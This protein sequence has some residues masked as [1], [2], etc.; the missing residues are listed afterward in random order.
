MMNNYGFA[1]FVVVRNPA[2]PM[3]RWSG[4]LNQELLDDNFFRSAIFLASQSLYNALHKKD[5]QLRLVHTRERLA[6]LKYLNRMSFRATPFGLFSSFCLSGWGSVRPAGPHPAISSAGTLYLQR[7]FY[8]MA[9]LTRRLIH[10]SSSTQLKYKSSEAWYTSQNQSRVLKSDAAGGNITIASFTLTAWLKQLL[11]YCQTS[12]SRKAIERKL[13]IW[14]GSKELAAGLFVQLIDGGLLCA[15]PGINVTGR[16]FT[17]KAARQLQPGQLPEF[18]RKLSTGAPF[19]ELALSPGGHY[20]VYCRKAFGK[21]SVS[22]QQLLLEGVNCLARLTAPQPSA[23]LSQFISRFRSRYEAA[24][25]PL[26]KALD[27]ELGL[28]YQPHEFRYQAEPL[29]DTIA[30]PANTSEM[31]VVWTPAHA[32]IASKMAKGGTVRLMETDLDNLPQIALNELPPSFSVLWQALGEKV[33]IEQAGGCSALSLSGRFTPFDAHLC[34]ALRQVAKEEDKRNPGI[35]FAEI[36]YL[37]AGKPANV[38]YRRSLRKFEIPVLTE[39][40]VDR[41]HVL[42]L[43]DLYLRIVEGKLVLYSKKL[44]QQ[45]VPRLS[46]VYNHSREEFPLFRFLCDLQYIDLRC[47]LTLSLETM[48]PGLDYYPRVEFRDCILSPAKW[49]LTGRDVPS[50]PDEMRS[51]AVSLGLPRHYVLT[52]GDHELLFDADCDKSLGMFIQICRPKHSFFLKESF[53]SQHSSLKDEKGNLYGAQYV[54]ALVK[55]SVTYPGTALPP[56]SKSV[57]SPGRIFLPGQEWLYLKIYCHQVSAK[58]ILCK[59][60]LTAMKK[61]KKKGLIRGWFFVRYHDPD[62]HLRL[63]IQLCKPGATGVLESMMSRL[64]TYV[65]SSLVHDVSVGIYQRELERYGADLITDCEEIFY[66]SSELVTAWLAGKGG[67]DDPTAFAVCSTGII[68]RTLLIETQ[69]IFEYVKMHSERMLEEFSVSKETRLSMDIK[70]RSYRDDMNRVADD[71]CSFQGTKRQMT[72]FLSALE[73][74]QTAAGQLSWQRR[75][76]LCSDLMHMH[77]NRLFSSEQRKKEMIIY[78]FLSKFYKSASGRL[79]PAGARR[80]VIKKTTPVM[81]NSQ[82]GQAADCLVA[83]RMTKEYIG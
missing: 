8:E 40:G 74:L 64:N 66:R 30:S 10:Q 60:I 77:L 24:E 79:K 38:N 16:D 83:E 51:L 47:S 42:K 58:E 29:I 81:I 43:D 12:R 13:S 4:E 19:K 9:A 73:K 52:E 54:T 33:L 32:L 50:T 31:Q 41:N 25:V 36:S 27:P 15:A 37:V 26:L 57:A 65:A 46:N 59:V 71:G 62:Y 82:S 20:A 28:G 45:V 68:L 39:A 22:Y 49:K 72:A 35:V 53:V 18:S 11:L 56:A 78:Y 14:C 17:E 23:G 69:V 80:P 76:K 34:S 6:L 55:Q 61:M 67:D 70:Y 7:D 1:A 5:F 44:N 63:R 75:Y 48:F 21:V 2:F 3:S